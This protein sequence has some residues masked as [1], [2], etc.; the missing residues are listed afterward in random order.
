MNFLEVSLCITVALVRVLE[1][2]EQ[3]IDLSLRMDSARLGV[4]E[5]GILK[6]WLSMDLGKESMEQIESYRQGAV[7]ILSTSFLLKD[8]KLG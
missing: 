5:M 2:T 4:W 8:P 3:V 6:H 1:T 7:F